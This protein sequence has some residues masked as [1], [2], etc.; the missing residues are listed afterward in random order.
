[1]K[2]KVVITGGNGFIGS[3]IVREFIKNKAEVTCL[4]RKNSSLT[5]ISGLNIKLVYGDITDKKSL[6]GVFAGADLVIHNAALSTD[7]ASYDKFRD[8]NVYGTV[9]VFESC[10]EQNVTRVIMT[11]SISSYGEEDSLEV[12]NED[13]PFN[14]H[15]SYFM[16]NLIP[17]KMNW[18]RDTKAE[19]TQK[20]MET[21]KKSG[22]NLM[23]LEPA[24]VYGEREF[25]T[26]F[27]E[28]VKSSKSGMI[29]APGSKKNYFPVIYAGDLAEAYWL[30]AIKNFSGI[31][32]IVIAN[33]NSELMCNIF[34]KFC[35][36][37]GVRKPI[38]CSKF[39]FYFPAIILEILYTVLKI[40]N[41]PLLTRGRV[42][43]FTDN[44]KFSTDKA[45]EILKF[46][47]ST[48]LDAGVAKTIQWYQN[49]GYL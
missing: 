34:R 27:Y 2:L 44:L 7:W 49:N 28:Y 5:N 15:Y 25:N 33:K 43:M 12:K 36:F 4:V 38:M 46:E 3:H 9:N 11:G 29:I 42:N 40:K 30:A 41:P 17:C 19:A 23:I 16:D 39:L 32:R 6:K 21:A 20:A 8:T 1:M 10:V 24:F 13:S 45:K 14:S 18:Y 22:I 37:A 47:S 48:S 31:E 35:V 26:G